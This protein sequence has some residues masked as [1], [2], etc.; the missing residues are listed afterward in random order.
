MGVYSEGQIGTGRRAS[1]KHPGSH[2]SEGVKGNPALMSLQSCAVGR[3]PFSLLSS[4][5]LQ[6]RAGPLVALSFMS[7]IIYPSLVF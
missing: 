1:G 7:D 3:E 5:K 2:G 6:I 4:K